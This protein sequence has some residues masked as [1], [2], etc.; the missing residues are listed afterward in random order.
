MKKLLVA[1]LFASLIAVGATYA[2]ISYQETINYTLEPSA[3]ATL[4]PVSLGTVIGGTSGSQTFT[5][6][7]TITVAL[8]G[9]VTVTATLGNFSDFSSFEVILTNANGNAVTISE[10]SPTGTFVINGPAT[11]AYDLYVSYTAKDGI[12]SKGPVLLDISV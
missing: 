9:P 7:V 4:V 11:T 6:A 5:D 8:Q 2:A 3:S 12:S 1:V 10:A